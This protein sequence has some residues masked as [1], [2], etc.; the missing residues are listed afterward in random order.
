MDAFLYKAA[1]YCS[2]CA[3]QI[4]KG[5]D[6]QMW[7]RVMQEDSEYVPQGPYPDGGGDADAPRHCDACGR[8]LE[9][10]LTPDGTRYL[11]EKLVEHARDGSGSQ[12]VLE[13][14]AAFYHAVVYEPGEVD[15]EELC[16]EYAL[17]FDGSD[18][19]REWWFKVAGELYARGEPLP[20]EW[21]YEPGLHPVDPDDIH[22]PLIAAASTATLRAF[23]EELIA[24]VGNKNEPGEEP[25][26]D[27]WHSGAVVKRFI[28]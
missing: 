20:D 28:E 9:N 19:A 8:F 14:W 18:D 5:R 15:L 1:L 13:E 21:K 12:T 3:A 26:A 27:G 16:T 10:P 7:P 24:E 23:A 25:L 11:I 2:D 17:H 22:A 6:V 4:R